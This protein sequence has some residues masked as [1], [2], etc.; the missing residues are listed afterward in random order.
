MVLKQLC[1]FPSIIA[2]AF[3]RMA[4]AASFSSWQEQDNDVAVVTRIRLENE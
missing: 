3:F 4:A 2:K 1:S